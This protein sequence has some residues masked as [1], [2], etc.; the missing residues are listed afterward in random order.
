M[1]HICLD[2][3]NND[4]RIDLMS[5]NA[6]LNMLNYNKAIIK[7]KL[8]SIYIGYLGIKISEGT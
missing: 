5:K 6:R 2:L 3:L 4:E 1:A 8:L 7:K